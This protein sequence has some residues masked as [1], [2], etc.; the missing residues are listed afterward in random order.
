M[1][2]FIFAC[3]LPYGATN[4]NH[5]EFHLALV[6]SQPVD[7]TCAPKTAGCV[8]LWHWSPHRAEH[9]QAWPWSVSSQGP[10]YQK[11]Y[12]SLQL[13]QYIHSSATLTLCQKQTAYLQKPKHA[14]CSISYETL[15]PICEQIGTFFNLSS[16][17]H[18]CVD[19]C[20]YEGFTMNLQQKP[21]T[22]SQCISAFQFFNSK[23]Q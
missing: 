13:N 11:S 8:S 2:M 23:Q 6:Y 18:Q 14:L 1:T 19:W 3:S 12:F 17:L 16:R 22:V 10:T 7:L 21:S 4:W 20:L 5:V 9:Q 15:L